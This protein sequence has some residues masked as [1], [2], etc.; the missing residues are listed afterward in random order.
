MSDLSKLVGELS[1]LTVTQSIELSKLL[2]EEWG[3]SAAAPVAAVA[4]ATGDDAG[5]SAV[6]QTEFD[7]I[8]TSFGS[9]KVGII[10]EVRTIT[11]L[12]LKS[13]KALVESAPTAVIK[14]KI[15]KDDAEAIKATIEGA[16]GSVEIK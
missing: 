2:E 8:L 5:A 10:K 15:S 4:A 1:S 9:A 11:G 6:E 16:G 14:E 12:D 7:V 3:V 13:A